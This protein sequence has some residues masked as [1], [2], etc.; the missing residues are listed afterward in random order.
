LKF[1]LQTFNVDIYEFRNKDDIFSGIQFDG[2]NFWLFSKKKCEILCWNEKNSNVEYISEF[3]EKFV[4]ERDYDVF[5]T[6]MYLEGKIW[7]LPCRA[8]SLIQ[9]DIKTKEIKLVNFENKLINKHMTNNMFWMYGGIHCDNNE[10][11]LFQLNTDGMVVTDNSRNEKY[12]QKVLYPENWE[13]IDILKYSCDKYSNFMEG[14]YGLLDTYIDFVRNRND[15]I[16]NVD[17]LY[18]NDFFEN[19]IESCGIKINDYLLNL[20]EI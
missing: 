11:L 15:G 4:C 7:I 16:K 1:D 6:T 3:P 9:F 17:N 13:D 2:E 10:I 8:N 14:N 12:V 5:L 19:D 18:F 20:L